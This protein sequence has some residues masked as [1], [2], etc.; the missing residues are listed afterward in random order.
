LLRP[1]LDAVF[2][3]MNPALTSVS[4]G[5]YYQGRHGRILRKRLREYC[6][7]PPLP[8]GIE[9]DQAEDDAAH[10]HGYGFADLVRRPTRSSKEVT[11]QEK[12]SGVI[13]L[14]NR[15][16]KTRDFPVI[17]FTYKEPFDFAAGYLRE[18][19]YRVFR[20]PHPYMEK[21]AADNM[22]RQLQ[23]ALGIE[24]GRRTHQSE[25]L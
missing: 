12:L 11:R 23:M 2:V 19:G 15:L 25:H 22:M 1:G 6:I 20:T 21:K 13:D 5:H 18:N 24:P 14:G 9:D 10:E 17:V 3:G 8:R 4:V 16:S 7:T